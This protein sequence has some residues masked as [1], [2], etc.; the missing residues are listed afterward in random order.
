MSIL[1]SYRT[2]KSR[3]GIS[4]GSLVTGHTYRYYCTGTVVEETR[5][6]T[7]FS[8][9]QPISF[10]Y[11]IIIPSQTNNSSSMMHDAVNEVL[12]RRSLRN[13]GRVPGHW[14]CLINTSR[15]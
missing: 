1:Y 13:F 6:E 15:N 9:R 5:L 2:P 3:F 4:E 10:S 7:P 14:S 8:G 11:G 12:I